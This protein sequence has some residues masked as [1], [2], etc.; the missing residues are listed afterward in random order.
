MFGYVTVNTETLTESEK[1]RFGEIYCGVCREL[2]LG[3][4]KCGQW[5]LSYDSAFLALL[6]NALYEPEEK[7][8]LARCGAHPAKKKPYALSEYTK[9]AADIN[10]LLFYLS[11]LD[12]WK[13]D[14]SSIKRV[15]AAVFKKRAM[16]AKTAYPRQ[17][18]AIEREL[19]AL[20][21][22]EEN[23]ENDPDAACACFGRLLGEVLVYKEDEWAQYLRRTGY[24]LG[25]FIYL[26][27]AWEDADKDAKSGSY[28]PLLF[29]RERADYEENV[30]NILMLEIADCAQAFE[31]L[32]IVR[33]AGILRNILYSGV[34]VKY[35]R[36]LESLQEKGKT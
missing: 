10:V 30:Y 32:P 7:R 19:E 9:Y 6:L 27:D 1:A 13:D 21:I 4:G 5:T 35:S 8:Y 33:D 34:W 26:M 23:R 11:A 18:Q 17:A 36:R 29:M 2:K 16:A 22:I 20:S 24:A 3:E 25:R 15:M 31:K 12:G 14:K 28:N